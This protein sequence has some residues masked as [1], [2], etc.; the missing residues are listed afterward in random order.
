MNIRHE[1]N[2]VIAVNYIPDQPSH[3]PFLLSLVSSFRDVAYCERRVHYGIPYNKYLDLF[4][5][6]Q[7]LRFGGSIG[8]T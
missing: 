2:L 8:D 1:K 6:R 5:Q 4:S 7:V 3:A